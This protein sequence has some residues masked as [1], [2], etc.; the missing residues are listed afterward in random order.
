MRTIHVIML[1][2]FH[3]DELEP[4]LESL[5]ARLSD[6]PADAFERDV[7]VVPN[8]GMKDAVLVGLARR[9][10]ASSSS[11]ADGIAANVDLMFPGRFIS[12]ALGMPSTAFLDVDPWQLPHL[13]WPVLD[14][15]HSGEVPSIPVPS[16]SA[17]HQW[18]LARRIADLFDR[19]ASQR[20]LMLR[21]WAAGRDH[22]AAFGLGGLANPLMPEHAWQPDTWRAVARRIGRETPAERNG[23]LAEAVASGEV[24]PAL[25]G[26]VSLFGFGALSPTLFSVARALSGRVDVAA[27][28]RHHSAAAWNSVPRV[29]EASTARAE[30]DATSGV[31]NP[32]LASWGRPALEAR[33]VLGA[34]DAV[35]FHDLSRSVGPEPT[36]VLAALQHDIRADQVPSVRSALTAGDGSIQIHACHGDVRQ[37]ESLRDALGHLFVADP[38]LEPHDVHIV[39]PDIARVAPLVQAVLG[40]GA[41]PIPVRVGD[42]ALTSDDPMGGALVALLELV[43][44]RASLTEVL[45][46]LQR[47]PVRQRLGWGPGD[48][49]RVSTWAADLGVRWGLEAEHRADWNLPADLATG[50]WRSLLDRLLAGLAMPAAT[51]RLVVGPTAPFDDLSAGD[52]GLVGT[53]ADLVERLVVLHDASRGTRPIGDWI[54]LLR[55]AV[56]GFLGAVGDDRFL[57]ADLHRTLDEIAEGAAGNTVPVG[58]TDV[59]DVVTDVLSE[60]PGRLSLRSGSVT[61]SSLVP[62]AG[63]PARV[64]CLVG[65]DEGSLRAGAFDG[66]DVLGVHP[67][68]GERHPRH[69]SRQLLLDAV[70]AAGENLIIT[71]QG[72]DLTT[73]KEVPFTVALAELLDVV[74]DTVDEGDR[75]V[76]RHPRHGFH[77]LALGAVRADGSPL[78]AALADSPFTFDELNRKAA[79]VRR[80]RARAE[81]LGELASPWL[82]EPLPAPTDGEVVTIDIEALVDALARP[83][84]LYLSNR[85]DVRLPGEDD[86]LDDLLPIS[87]G[88]L[89]AAALGREYLELLAAAKMDVDWVEAKMLDGT[90]PPRALGA[91]ALDAVTADVVQMN[92]VVAGY[93]VPLRG[94]SDQPLDLVLA[95]NVRLTGTITGLAE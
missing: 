65:L 29:P 95:D 12:L 11:S 7:V 39:C 14:V 54:D 42:R 62:L 60:A 41:L 48:V 79:E 82:L 64:I 49:E 26:R 69:E 13:A 74:R 52:A 44:G 70:L 75:V 21:E 72:A 17:E 66:D 93:D 90:M 58:L 18:L 84:R 3:A 23:R 94:A 91:S 34:V 15:I 55:S 71:C 57:L 27:Y 85:L 43:A 9:L 68:V 8:A 53:F 51:P 38:T 45:G 36:T 83:A 92:E 47:G 19:Y 78:M 22:D 33:A 80:Q 89:G 30:F 56:D 25:P 50:T 76:V 32:L 46:F 87:L 24:T 77:E 1:N 73:N 16:G 4:L 6:A 20:E 59:R 86:P 61:V 10:G 67:V 88:P 31:R 37:L 35:A 2:V 28:V 40:R 63:V 5:A 81:A